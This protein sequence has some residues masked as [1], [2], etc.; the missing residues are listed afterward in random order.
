[1]LNRSSLEASP[2]PAPESSAPAGGLIARLLRPLFTRVRID[3]E[4]ETRL[5]NAYR[6]GIVV[7]VFRASRLT[8]PLFLLHALETRG[9]PSP[10]WMH[11]HY[12]SAEEDSAA[13]LSESIRAGHSAVLFLRRPRTLLSPTGAY[14]EK[15]VEALLRV[16]R[17]L[18][19][20]ILL[21]PETLH[22]T[23]RPVGLR[24]TVVDSVFGNRE[25]PGWARE[26]VG[27]LWNYKDARFHVGAPSTCATCSN[28]PR[29]PI[30]PRVPKKTAAV[31]RPKI[32]SSRGRSDGSSPTTSPARSSCGR[33]RWC[34][35]W[36][37]RGRWC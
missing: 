6:Q 31:H 22:W 36:L 7:H 17:D 30:S 4:A 32:R 5:V 16:Q 11:D 8:D 15:H 18:D 21:L 1:M 12:A 27:F 28:A 3:D 10:Q 13:A 20:P 33:G 19:R 23:K 25:A 2:P 14:T 26:I 34:A 9:L 24:P 29:S 37:A 35:A